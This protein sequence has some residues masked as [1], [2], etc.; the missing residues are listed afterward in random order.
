MTQ[1]EIICDW[2][3]NQ[4]GICETP[5]G[6]NDVVYNTL[7]YGHAV[8][9]DRYPWCMAFVWCAFSLNDMSSLFYGGKKTASCTTLMR[10]AKSVG[11]FYGEGFRAGD[12]I[13]YNFDDDDMSEHTGI[14]VETHGDTDL[15]VVEGNCGNE[16]KLTKPKPSTILGVF[17]PKYKEAQ[18]SAPSYNTCKPSLPVLQRGSDDKKMGG[19]AVWA[20]QK[21]LIKQG[22]S[23]G[24]DGADGEF[25]LNTQNGV[26]N[27]QRARGLTTDGIVGAETWAALMR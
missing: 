4:I 26:R 16:V 22:F 17:R 18:P 13:F 7:Y 14:I 3:R 11:Q 25:G 21:M 8:S 6:S 2:A 23:V 15:R 24:P 12:I 27:F 10:W 20:L 9:G 1:A 5:P 19:I